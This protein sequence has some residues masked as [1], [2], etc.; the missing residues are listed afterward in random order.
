MTAVDQ[1]LVQQIFATVEE[2]YL[3]DICNRITNSINDTVAD[4]LTQ[5]QYNYG[6][7]MPHELLERKDIIKNTT[8]KP[9]ETIATIFSSVE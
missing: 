8:Y 4:V 9:R 5:L 6:Q 1:S 2:D 3:A 7:L